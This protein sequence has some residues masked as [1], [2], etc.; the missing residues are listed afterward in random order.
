MQF[1]SEDVSEVSV[2]VFEKPKKIG[3]TYSAH[4]AA[5]N[6]LFQKSSNLQ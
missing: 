3:L 6:F 2:K 4:F 1:L 5:K